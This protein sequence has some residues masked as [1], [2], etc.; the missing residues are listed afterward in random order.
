M[1]F[2]IES[3]FSKSGYW[4][5]IPG[6]HRQDAILKKRDWS[7]LGLLCPS[8]WLSNHN[9]S[10]SCPY[11]QWHN[12]WLSNNCPSLL[13]FF[14]SF[15]IITQKI[16]SNDLKYE[17][18]WFLRIYFFFKNGFLT[19]HCFIFGGANLCKHMRDEIRRV[20]MSNRMILCLDAPGFL[21]AEIPFPSSKLLQCFNENTTP[22][23]S[24]HL[25]QSHTVLSPTSAAEPFNPWTVMCRSLW[26]NMAKAIGT[27]ITK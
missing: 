25:C 12:S 17:F 7:I 2:L 5:I 22:L 19:S 23:G 15:I 21:Q 8:S 9:L 14:L 24:L 3:L 4:L 10:C 26:V 6:K 13:L 1:L 11:L 16:I 20:G 18:K 27:S